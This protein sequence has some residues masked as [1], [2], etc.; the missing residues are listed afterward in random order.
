[1]GKEFQIF[2]LVTFSVY[3]VMTLGVVISYLLQFAAECKEARRRRQEREARQ[4]ARI[5]QL[6]EEFNRDRSS[7]AY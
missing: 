6:L 4:H 7:G 2:L 3:A 1:M 5:A